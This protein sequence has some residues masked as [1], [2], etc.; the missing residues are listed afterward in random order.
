MQ[1]PIKEY[2]REGSFSV[3]SELIITKTILKIACALYAPNLVVQES[4][5][6]LIDQ[7]AEICSDSLN[8][9]KQQFRTVI[10]EELSLKSLEQKHIPKDKRE[11]VQSE[12]EQLLAQV[13]IT[14]SRVAYC[15]RDAKLLAK[16]LVDYYQNKYTH[17]S[18]EDDQYIKVVLL[19]M[20]PKLVD[21]LQKDPRYL[22]QGIIGLY[23]ESGEMKQQ[24]EELKAQ[25][26]QPPQTRFPSFLSDPPFD[27]AELF[28]GRKQIVEEVVR[29]IVDGDT[30]TLR[31]RRRGKNRDSKGGRKTYRKTM[32]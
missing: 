15:N 26:I 30:V 8:S 28:L 7:T 23:E 13:P 12:T 31:N 17:Y 5:N 11:Y 3:L 21:C 1:K 4:I 10:E 20:L 22:F 24:I 14:P 27:Q 32:L 29:R 19:S 9:V 18:V 6:A 16:E 25:I 2:T